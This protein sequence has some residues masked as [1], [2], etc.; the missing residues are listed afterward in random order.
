M[1]YTEEEEEEEEEVRTRHNFRFICAYVYAACSARNVNNYAS[2]RALQSRL[3]QDKK[4]SKTSI[5]MK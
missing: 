3:S 1:V 4:I 5:K 2:R